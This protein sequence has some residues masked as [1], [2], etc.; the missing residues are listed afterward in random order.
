MRI[1]G[2]F[3]GQKEAVNAL[4]FILIAAGISSC[5]PRKAAP[6]FGP[7]EVAVISIKP[8]RTVLTTE[9]PGRVT[10]C[11]VAEVRPEVGGTIQKRFFEE[12]ADVKA[13]DLLYQIDDDTYK[14]AYDKAKAELLRAE[15]RLTPL[16]NKLDRCRVLIQS[17]VISQQDLENAESDL[18]S[19]EAD[20]QACKANL[21][22]ASI[23]LENTKLIAPISGRI[24]K[25][26]VT[27]GA[28]ITE[29]YATP[30][31]TI[32]QLDPIFVDVTQSSSDFLRLR[33]NIT[34]GL[35]K[36][37]GD[38]GATARLLFEDSSAYHLT[39]EVQFRDVTVEQ[40]TGSC[41]L[42][43]VFPNP[44]KLL[45]PGMY[46]RV[47]IEEGVVENAILVPHQAVIRNMRG[48]P[49]VMVVDSSEKV[50]MRKISIDRSLGE[51]WLV[52]DG[53]KAGD[54]V[55]MEGFQK[56]RPGVSVKVVPFDSKPHDA[57]AAVPDKAE[58]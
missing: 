9:L 32:Q 43:I 30:L 37:S 10:A 14:A 4:L 48:E 42:R 19:A 51:K 27:V 29:N 35:I 50:D 55:I 49:A 8:E 17:M 28:L 24:G 40:D 22:S 5:G 16:K 38:K 47:V 57:G 58:K 33:H 15:A 13:G 25:S 7:P 34:E 45:L 41:I 54:R 31:A 12:G 6:D 11:L 18:Q 23:D 46:V 2:I 21:E 56:I 20:I 44:E 3:S 26:H 52:K 39:G 36:K 1:K 53:I